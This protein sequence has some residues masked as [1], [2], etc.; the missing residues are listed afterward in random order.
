[1]S[2]IDELIAELAPKGV[3]HVALSEVAEYSSTRIDAADL[4]AA[5]FV[6]VDNLVANKGG[7]VDASYLPNTAR[8]TAYE[9]GDILLGNIRPYLKKV[10]RA[11]SHG[12][13]SGDVLAI[14][15]MRELRDSLDFDFLYY[16]MS[17]DAFF[18]YNMQNSKGAKMP[19]GNKSE[20]M[21][22]RIPVPPLEVQREIVRILD[23]FTALEEELEAE[24]EARRHQYEYYR[25]EALRF[26][27]DVRSVPLGDVI[28]ELRT[29]LN[30]RQNFKLNTPGAT[31]HY[32]TVR[33]LAGFNILPTDKTDLVND[34][35]LVRIQDR[36]RLQVGDVLF[37]GTGTIGRTA[38]VEEEPTSWNIKEGIYA[39]TPKRDLISSRFLIHLL[40]SSV[41]R[42]RILGTAAGS[43]VASVS[44]ASLRR[45][46]LPVPSMDEQE[47]ITALLDNFE[48]LTNDL[49]IGLPAELA[50]RRKQ[51]EYYRDQLLTFEEAPA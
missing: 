33:E 29:G 45:V 9:P 51:Y 34:Q 42:Q 43:T 30:P 19:R 2:H 36:S 11:T 4:N 47:R 12:G 6:G 27:D 20:I 17:S 3:Y 48:T 5:N 18:A 10:W 28:H 32:I 15:I 46:L 14:R 41:I 21:K 44:M 22:Y 1:M 16:L 13:C 50:A 38:L 40:R 39:L 8:L 31:N 24:L 49:S 25:D 37:S 26:G 23:Q 35:G 7:R